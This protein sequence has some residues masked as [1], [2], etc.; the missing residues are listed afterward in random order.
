MVRH[1]ITGS[2]QVESISVGEGITSWKTALS[3][4]E[5]WLDVLKTFHLS[6]GKQLSLCDKG[7]SIFFKYFVKFKCVIYNSLDFLFFSHPFLAPLQRVRSLL[8]QLN[9]GSRRASGNLPP[10]GNYRCYGE[11]SKGNI[12]TGWGLPWLTI[13]KWFARILNTGS[14]GQCLAMLWF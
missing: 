8:S 3:N 7:I 9:S 6:W 10:W 13:L 5:I 12:V 1:Q 2:I 4:R 14:L 11:S